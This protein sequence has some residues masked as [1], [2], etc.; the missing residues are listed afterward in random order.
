M[1]KQL[2]TATAFFVAATAQTIK[3]PM[4]LAAMAVSESRA[5]AEQFTPL[6]AEAAGNADGSIPAWTVGFSRGV[7]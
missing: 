6:G 2:L 5:V 7:E 4:L 1:I 3:M